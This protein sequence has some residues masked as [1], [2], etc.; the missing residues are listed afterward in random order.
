MSSKISEGELEVFE[1]ME[2]GIVKNDLDLAVLGIRL[3]MLKDYISDEDKEIIEIARKE[4]SFYPYQ[5]HLQD[6][7]DFLKEYSWNYMC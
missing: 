2:R 6:V 7:Y 5:T 3:L 1:L 4:I